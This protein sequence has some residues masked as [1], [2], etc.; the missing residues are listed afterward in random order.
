MLIAQSVNREANVAKA[1]NKSGAD[2]KNSGTVVRR[3]KASTSS[4]SARADEKDGA[5][6][7]RS[8]KAD[9]AD[10][11]KKPREAVKTKA[12]TAK[13]ARAHHS[14]SEKPPFILFRPFCA[15]GRYIRDSWRELRQVRWPNRKLTWQLTL[16]VIIFSVVL[17][18][19]VLLADW[20]FQWIVEEIIL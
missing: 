17:A 18:L 12:K 3:V 2:S 15:I 8:V 7:R 16:A 13:P 5:V 1:Q 9:T 4:T 10:V 6:I 20:V 11:A 19:I 14:D